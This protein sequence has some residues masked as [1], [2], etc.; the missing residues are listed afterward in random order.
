MVFTLQPAA[1]GGVA[2]MG[3]PC[4]PGE[5]G[6]TLGP[7]EDCCCQAVECCDSSTPRPACVCSHRGRPTDIPLGPA[8]GRVW[9]PFLAMPTPGVTPTAVTVPGP[10]P[11]GHDQVGPATG[12]HKHALLCVWRM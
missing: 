6:V 9:I 8:T 11:T 1:M 7:G 2:M 3:T 12:H 4:D 5:G 10:M